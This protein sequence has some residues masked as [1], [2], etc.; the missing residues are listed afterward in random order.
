M[1]KKKKAAT[2]ATS[3]N[4]DPFRNEV[5][6]SI[7]EEEVADSRERNPNSDNPGLVISSLAIIGSNNY[8]ALKNSLM[9]TLTAKDELKYI[10]SEEDDPE[11]DTVGFRRWKRNDCLVT[12][13]ILNT[14]SRELVEGF[15]YVNSAKELWKSLEYMFCEANAPMLFK[16]KRDLNMFE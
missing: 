5:D 11:E 9:R 1:V 4:A 3:S 12:A 7:Y 15:T 8:L 10:P 6:R 16:I 14:I 13:W 2:R